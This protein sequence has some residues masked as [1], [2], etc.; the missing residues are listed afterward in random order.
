MAK[1][2]LI[3]R[4][5]KIDLGKCADTFGGD[6]AEDDE[7]IPVPQEPKNIEFTDAEDV[8]DKPEAQKGVEEFPEV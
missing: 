2:T 7:T 4:A 6:D 5:I 3:N 8:T 1:R